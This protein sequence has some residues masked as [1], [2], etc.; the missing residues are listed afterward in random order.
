MKKL[1]LGSFT[2]I[3]FSSAI[4]L[5]QFSCTKSADAEP[6]PG[7]NGSAY[8]LPPATSTTLGGVIVG[9]GLT[10][11][12]TGVLSANSGGSATQ[13]NKVVFLKIDPTKTTEIWSMNYDGTGQAKVN[14]SLAAGLEIAGHPRLSPDGKKLFFVVQDT[15]VQG[16]KDDIYS[17]NFDGTGVTKLYDMPAGSGHTEL[18]GAY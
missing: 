8:K 15:K 16:N 11:S 10:V 13:L 7:G 1:I 14:I 5:F 6:E 4:L 12:S 9:S 17:C 2:L 18:G 3:L